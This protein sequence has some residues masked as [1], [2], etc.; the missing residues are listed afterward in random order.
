MYCL[1]FNP[2]ANGLFN[3]PLL[4]FTL[5]AQLNLYLALLTLPLSFGSQLP[6]VFA[7]VTV[8]CFCSTNVVVV[9]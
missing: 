7:A 4:F 6:F 1:L 2:N 3:I 9:T 8:C 5:T